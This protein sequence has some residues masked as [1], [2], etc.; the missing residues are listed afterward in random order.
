MAMSIIHNQKLQRMWED[1][2]RKGEWATTRLSEHTFKLRYSKAKTGPSY[3]SSPPTEADDD[4]R[5]INIIAEYSDDTGI[6]TRILI[7]VIGFFVGSDPS[8]MTR[9]KRD[10]HCCRVLCPGECPGECRNC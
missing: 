3:R 2:Q 6:W 4:L 8:R 7:G 1:A 5:R 10:G 9:I